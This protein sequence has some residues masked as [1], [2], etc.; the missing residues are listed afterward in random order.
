MTQTRQGRGPLRLPGLL[1]LSAAFLPGCGGF[2]ADPGAADRPVLPPAVEAVPARSGTLP[3]MERLSGVARAADQ[4]A[5]RPEIAGV[6]SEVLVRS[7]A[8]VSRGQALVRLRNTTQREQ[9]EQAE[10]ALRLARASATEA[11]ARL[12]EIDAQVSRSRALAAQ[13]LISPMELETLEARL[14]AA[15]A[16]SDQAHARVD[17]AGATVAERREDLARTV[18]RAPIDG[19]VGRRNVEVGMRVDTGTLLFTLG[20]LDQLI[21]EVPLTEAMM[22]YLEEGQP[23]LLS[24]S[25]GK[26]ESLGATLS[27]IS[28][29]LAEGSFSTVGEIDVDNTA[30]RLQPGMFVTADVLYGE[31]GRAT[32]VP[33][34]ALWEDP[35]TRERVLFV[36]DS[37]DEHAAALAATGELSEKPIPV[38]R[39]DVEVVAEGRS[40]MGVRGVEEGEWVVTV[41]QH[42]LAEKGVEAARVR[43]TTWERVARMQGLQREDLLEEFLGKQRR[44]ARERGVL[45]PSNEEYVGSGAGAASQSP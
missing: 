9:L 40:S 16:A 15:Q 41:G 45:P 1:I 5:L 14:A 17:Q 39:R 25:T 6:V 4:V 26:N 13:E 10:A 23:V 30:G 3:L 22:G 34:S 29:F 24:T 12:R 33:T 43:P 31:S 11:D 38:T 21:V 36:V 19:R 37:G 2:G 28:P 27:R 20:S 8:A 18:V 35:R 44:L 32:L 42:L 7:G